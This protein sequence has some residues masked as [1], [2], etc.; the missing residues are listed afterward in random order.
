MLSYFQGHL[1]NSLPQLHGSQSSWP[2]VSGAGRRSYCMYTHNHWHPQRFCCLTI[3][4]ALCSD[5]LFSSIVLLSSNF[6]LPSLPRLCQLQ[7][8]WRC[9][10]RSTLAFFW[11]WVA[12][13]TSPQECCTTAA[14]FSYIMYSNSSLPQSILLL[15]ISPTAYQ[16]FH[17]QIFFQQGSL[18]STVW[19]LCS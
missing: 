19:S 8:I 12:S 18:Y 11:M 1:E 17:L 3:W 16:G 7:L 2:E 5:F 14:L 10:V 9:C 13:A 4:H 15:D 6:G